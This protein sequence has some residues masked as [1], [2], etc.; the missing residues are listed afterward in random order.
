MPSVPTESM[1]CITKAIACKNLSFKLNFVTVISSLKEF[2]LFLLGIV[3]LGEEK[4]EDCFVF[5]TSF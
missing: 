1:F 5:V 4:K 2:I 3:F